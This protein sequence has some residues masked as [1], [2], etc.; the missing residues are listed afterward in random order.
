MSILQLTHIS[1]QHYDEK[2]FSMMRT[3]SDQV[4]M[5]VICFDV[6]KSQQ[7]LKSIDM[8]MPRFC[9]MDNAVPILLVGCNNSGANTKHVD[10]QLLQDCCK[11]VTMCV[12]TVLLNTSDTISLKKFWR[13][14]NLLC[15]EPIPEAKRAIPAVVKQKKTACT[16]Q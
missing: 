3:I 2:Y 1:Q 8:R 6:A 16:I 7:E 9:P 4:Q 10:L 12:G 5:V 11:D 15:L 13:C 14:V